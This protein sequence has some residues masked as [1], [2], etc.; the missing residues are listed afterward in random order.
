MTESVIDKSCYRLQ[1]VYQL[2]L[3]EL[4]SGSLHGRV[5]VG[6]LAGQD[7]VFLGKHAYN[8][9]MLADSVE[10]FLEAERLANIEE[11]K[12]VSHQA[13]I[14]L[15]KAV[16][17]HDAR[18]LNRETGNNLL[19][20]PIGSMSPGMTMVERVQNIKM[21]PIKLVIITSVQHNFLLAIA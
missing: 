12:S 20:Q 18:V 2:P 11:K 17:E 13:G 14:L 7:C 9:G 3:Q 16:K 19:N 21:N 4:S 1:S 10:W 6:H 15:T 5:A 8:L